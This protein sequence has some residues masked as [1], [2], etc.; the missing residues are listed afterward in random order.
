[1]VVNSKKKMAT[2][3]RFHM[4]KWL[5]FFITFTLVVTTKVCSEWKQKRRKG[6]KLVSH[7]E[8]EHQVG[9]IGV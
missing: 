6:L 2:N 9:G 1:L 5:L 8:S 7:E 4:K 3:K